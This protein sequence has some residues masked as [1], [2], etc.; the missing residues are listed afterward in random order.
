[1]NM[2]FDDGVASSEFPVTKMTFP[3]AIKVVGLRDR[4]LD[5]SNYSNFNR[6]D[7]K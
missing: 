1:M 2:R 4:V 3:Q 7:S 6:V 5:K